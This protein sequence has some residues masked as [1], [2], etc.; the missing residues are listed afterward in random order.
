MGVEVGMAPMA[1]E[2]KRNGFMLN[3]AAVNGSDMAAR[4]PAAVSG[5]GIRPDAEL[6][7]VAAVVV[8]AFLESTAFEL[9]TVLVVV[10]I[11]AELGVCG[12]AFEVTGDCV[13][14][15]VAPLEP[16]AAEVVVAVCAPRSLML[17]SDEPRSAGLKKEEVLPSP[18]EGYPLV[19][20]V[21]RPR[22]SPYPDIP[23]MDGFINGYMKLA[24]VSGSMPETKIFEQEAMR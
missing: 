12:V 15:P 2:P 10:V 3:I 9:V 6:T 5:L 17:K 7:A 24:D 13:A 4:E 16:D 1:A 20:D 8:V 14:L 22:G 23:S 21:G 19:D 11:G 18:N